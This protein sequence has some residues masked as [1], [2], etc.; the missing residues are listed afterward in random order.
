[1]IRTPPSSE[2]PRLQRLPWLLAMAILATF[3]LSGRTATAHGLGISQLRLR[4]TASRVE[5]EWEIQVRD[6]RIALGL[7]PHVTGEAGWLDLRNHEASLR[8]YVIGRLA[9]AADGRTCPLEL[10]A[11]PLEWQR[12][13][14]QVLLHLVSTCASEPVRLLMRCDLLFD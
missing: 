2:R 8:E 3:V 11:A 12:D 13:Q 4:V 14:S 9:L 10:T 7:D 5:G 6:A 1:M